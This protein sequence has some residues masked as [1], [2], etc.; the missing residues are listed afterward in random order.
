MTPKM[1]FKQWFSA[2]EKV[3]QCRLE[4]LQFDATGF[5]IRYKADRYPDGRP[6][7]QLI[8]F[9]SVRDARDYWRGYDFHR[10]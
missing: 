2:V 8:E 7:P 10:G 4:D 5:P 1:T 9:C 6:A 3:R